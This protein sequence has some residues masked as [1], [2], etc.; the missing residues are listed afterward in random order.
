MKNALP[1]ILSKSGQF[2]DFLHS[3]SNIGKHFTPASTHF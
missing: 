1:R 2:E 3:C